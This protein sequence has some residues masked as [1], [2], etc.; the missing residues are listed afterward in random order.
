[1]AD[2]LRR[3]PRERVWRVVGT[4]R[5]SDA[6]TMRYRWSTTFDDVRRRPYLFRFRILG[7]GRSN[8]TEAEVYPHPTPG[9]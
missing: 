4:V 1:M 6:G 5:V 9:P 3:D 8:P 7:H 2:V